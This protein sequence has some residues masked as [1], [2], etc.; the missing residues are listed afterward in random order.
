MFK[1]KKVIEALYDETSCT[2]GWSTN[3]KEFF[4]KSETWLR[5]RQNWIRSLK[6][7]QNRLRPRE[8]GLRWA[9]NSYFLLMLAPHLSSQVTLAQLTKKSEQMLFSKLGRQEM[10][11]H[12]GD[13]PHWNLAY[14]FLSQIIQTWNK[15]KILWTNWRSTRCRGAD[16]DVPFNTDVIAAH[17]LLVWSM[18]CS[19]DTSSRSIKLILRYFYFAASAN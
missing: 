4:A 12:P 6:R 8:K 2:C 7:Q 1:W 16:V 3:L 19:H 13:D 11:S 10:L 9:S 17:L 18:K 14:I 5:L 15:A